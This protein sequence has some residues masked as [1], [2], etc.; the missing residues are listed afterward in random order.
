MKKD[1]SILILGIIVVATPFLGVPSPWKTV[2]FVG[3]GLTIAALAYLLQRDVGG[4]IH[5]EG[6]RKTEMFVENDVRP[7]DGAM[8]KKNDDSHESTS[9]P[10]KE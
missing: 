9:P 2:I 7:I 1:T 8:K 6:D 4:E 5:F 3:A 10:K